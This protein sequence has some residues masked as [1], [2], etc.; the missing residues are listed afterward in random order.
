MSFSLAGLD[1]R[2][3][4]VFSAMLRRVEALED[5]NNGLRSE[6]ERLRQRL[7]VVQS[8][9]PSPV[10]APTYV[11]ASSNFN[12]SLDELNVYMQV[13]CTSACAVTLPAVVEG[14]WL[15]LFNSGTADLTVKTGSTT[16]ICVLRPNALCSIRAL[17]NSSGVPSW[18]GALSQIGQDGTTWAAANVII[19]STSAA[20]LQ[21]SSDGHYYLLTMSTSGRLVTSDQGTVHPD[22]AT[23][24][25]TPA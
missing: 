13:N 20:V 25:A 11:S 12:L 24:E 1:A 19:D 10:S 7:G 23:A 14:A 15:I 21:K 18:P 8:A 16:T 2:T 17:V 3:Q 6:V 5:A 4:Q 9:L 22:I